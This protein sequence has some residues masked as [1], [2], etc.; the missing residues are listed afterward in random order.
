MSKSDHNIVTSMLSAHFYAVQKM[1]TKYC[2]HNHTQTNEFT[3]S[4]SSLKVVYSYQQ[5]Q[6]LFTVDVTSSIPV[7]SAKSPLRKKL[8][9]LLVL[10][11]QASFLLKK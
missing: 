11:M 4:L 2:Q 10:S 8:Q 1:L 3:F 6:K 5:Q 7:N 9:T